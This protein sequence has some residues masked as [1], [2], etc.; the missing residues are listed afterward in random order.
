LSAGTGVVHSEVNASDAVTRYVQMWLMADDE[1]PPEYRVAEAPAGDRVFAVI[2][3]GTASAPVRLRQPDATLSA[4]N[5]S[6]GD[7]TL[8]PA[9]AFA[10]LYVIEGAAM[11]GD[12]PLLAGDAA[13]IVDAAGLAVTADLDSQLLLWSMDAETWRPSY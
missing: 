8:L 4:A 7:A 10:H 13:R 2:A 5:L 11:L 6:P 1:T 9:A 12:V 3:S